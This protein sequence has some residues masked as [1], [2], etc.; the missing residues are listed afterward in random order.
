MT[1]ER[2][3]PEY[4]KVLVIVLTENEQENK[5]YYNLFKLMLMGK[6]EKEINQPHRKEFETDKVSIRFFTK[7]LEVRG[8]KAHYVI[9]LTQDKEYHDGFAIPITSIHDYLKYDEKWSDLFN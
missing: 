1:E 7:K 9:N 4:Q 3:Y 8:Y 6:I 2:Y 5:K